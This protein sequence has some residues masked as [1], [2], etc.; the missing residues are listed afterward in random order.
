MLV[1]TDVTKYLEF[2]QIDGS[3]VVAK[4]QK[5]HKVPATDNEA[6]RSGLMGLLEKN[7]ARKFFQFLQSYNEA[8][9]KTHNGLNMSKATMAE[10]YKKFGLSKGT[11]E[12]IGHSLALHLN[13]DYLTQPAAD[14]IGKIRLY[15][16][17]LARYGKS[18]YIYPLYGLGELPQ[19][20]ARLSAIYGGTYM[21]DRKFE[22]IEV[23]SS[24]KFVGV[25][26]D[27]QVV[28]A[29]FVVGDPSY[30]PD[31]VNKTGQIVRSINI[32]R[33]DIENTKEAD[34]V[35]IIIPQSAVGRNSDIY[36]SVVSSAHNI[37]AKGYKVAM[38]STTVESDNPDAELKHGVQH[39]PDIRA[40]FTIVK[41][42]YEPK[43][44]GADSRIFI[45][46]SYD[47]TSHFETSSNDI[48][49]IWQRIT[50]KPL[51]LK[52]LDEGEDGGAA[53]SSSQS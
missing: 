28:K 3:Y 19:A 35:Q 27:G 6:L 11:Q 39:L 32:I 2:K 34:S 14:T 26:A 7:R 21:L 46:R 33:G 42:S 18:P 23:D 31:H 16:E 52:K 51:E 22:G 9:S 8:D 5:V 37:A 40:S 49:D 44:D 41:D 30:F 36:V 10:V 20:F 45:S 50:G 4:D 1:H 38:V 43:D 15:V 47:A 48:A 13:D 25:K 12:F 29:K 24:G 53:A 17:S